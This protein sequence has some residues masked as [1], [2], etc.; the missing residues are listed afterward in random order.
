VRGRWPAA[1]AR[2]NP[3]CKTAAE[4]LNC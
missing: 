2:E 3:E 1:S 4:P